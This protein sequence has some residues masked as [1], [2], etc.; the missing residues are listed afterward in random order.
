M[1]IKSATDLEGERNSEIWVQGGKTVQCRLRLREQARIAL[2]KGDVID[3]KSEAGRD[4]SS[5]G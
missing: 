1:A 3:R 2:N 5:M 4:L